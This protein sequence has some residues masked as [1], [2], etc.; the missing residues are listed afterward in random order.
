MVVQTGCGG[1]A[2]RQA[3]MVAWRCPRAIGTKSRYTRLC[4][5]RASIDGT[6]GG[7][8]D[9]ALSQSRGGHSKVVI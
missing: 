9:D 8:H 2:M 5:S 6:R 1:V 3:V 7:E 4:F